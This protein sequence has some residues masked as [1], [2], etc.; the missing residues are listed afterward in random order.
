MRQKEGGHWAAQPLPPHAIL[1]RAS[2][3]FAFQI[4]EW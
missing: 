4:L 3:F 2:Q 1:I